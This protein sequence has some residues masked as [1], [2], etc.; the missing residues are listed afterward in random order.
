MSLGRRKYRK[1]VERSKDFLLYCLLYITGIALLLG[2]LLTIER[3][4]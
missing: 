3:V 2:I 1:Y 4:I